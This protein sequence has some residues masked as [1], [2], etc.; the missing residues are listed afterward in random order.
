[1]ATTI[2]SWVTLKNP[3][4]P[5]SYGDTSGAHIIQGYT[6][7]NTTIGTYSFIPTAQ[8]E[9]INFTASLT[10]TLN[11]VASNPTASQVDG[12]V[13]QAFRKLGE[14][15][16]LFVNGASATSSVILGA[17]FKSDTLTYAVPVSKSLWVR[18]INNGSNYI[19]TGTITSA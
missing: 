14:I 1:M 4:V 18:G 13:T 17:G 19:V 7:T 8:M 12:S 9:Y 2:N 3:I 11:I 6:E 16:M 5:N 15:S 10:G